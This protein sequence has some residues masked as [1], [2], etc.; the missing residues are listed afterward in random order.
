VERPPG[1]GADWRY[2]DMLSPPFL[3]EKKRK[4]GY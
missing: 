1:I 2:E 3:K 4:S